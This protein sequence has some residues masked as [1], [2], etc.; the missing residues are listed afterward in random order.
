MADKIQPAVL[1][2]GLVV[3]GGLVL[4]SMRKKSRCEKL[5]E[6]Y[7]EDGPLHLT[8]ESQDRA[9]EAARYKIREHLLAHQDGMNFDEVMLYVADELR[10]CKWEK[11][12]TAEQKAVWAGIR[13]IVEDVNEQAIA[14]PDKFRE[15]F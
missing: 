12:K 5:P 1:A 8:E 7:T 9:R 4:Y 10:D 11:L 2:V 13:H 14:D 3:V 15:S 6:I